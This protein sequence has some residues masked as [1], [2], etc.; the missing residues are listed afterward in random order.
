[1]FNSHSA[2]ISPRSQRNDYEDFLIDRLRT[3]ERLR[4]SGGNDKAL[5]QDNFCVRGLEPFQS[6]GEHEELFSK[7]RCHQSTILIEQV[8][9]SM[10][11]MRNPE[12]FRLMVETQSAISERRA[13]EL[14]AVDEHAVHGSVSRRGSLLSTNNF[15]GASKDAGSI[16][17]GLDSGDSM[18]LTQRIRE[19]Q[20]SNARRL[21]EIYSQPGYNPF[22]FPIRRDSL[23]AGGS[24][25][26]RNVSLMNNRFP[27]RRDSLTP[28]GATGLS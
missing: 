5:D 11:G 10:Y 17:S 4:A 8:R 21:I 20:E 27:I 24:S 18:S 23:L 3:I 16:Q 1:M 7:R 15:I 9:Q 12:R 28:I 26:M 19:L 6:P 22:R 14:A 13:R 25:D 2:V